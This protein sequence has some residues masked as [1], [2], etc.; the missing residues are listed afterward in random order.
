MSYRYMKTGLLL[1]LLILCLT[2]CIGKG[3]KGK[4]AEKQ[5][6][7]YEIC[8]EDMLPDELLDIIEQ[9]KERRFKLS[10]NTSKYTYIAIGYGM[11]SVDGYMVWL[12]DIYATDKAC[13]IQCSLVTRDYVEGLGD[14]AKDMVLSEASVCPYM[15]IRCRRLDKTV[16][17]YMP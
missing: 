9:K 3:R 15:V 1:C 12:K 4:E 13:Y 17:Y 11:H 2:G 5:N 16:A 6:V 8:S 10:Y 7:E 14:G